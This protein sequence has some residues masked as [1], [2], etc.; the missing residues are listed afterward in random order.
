MFV[1]VGLKKSHLK[2]KKTSRARKNEENP[3]DCSFFEDTAIQGHFVE[4]KL[5]NGL[6]ECVYQISGLL[7]F[8][9]PVSVAVT[10]IYIVL[11]PV[12]FE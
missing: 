3:R 2:I 9:W 11:R 4:K 12:D 8:V 1:C 6:G 7:F 10:H 5:R